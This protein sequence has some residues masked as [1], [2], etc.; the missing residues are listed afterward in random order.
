MIL[1]RIVIRTVG[2]FLI[3]PCQPV[4]QF[5]NMLESHLGLSHDRACVTQNHH[6]GQITD[7]YPT[8]YRNGTLRRRLQA[9]ENLQHGRFTGSILSYQRNAVLLIDDKRN[10]L[11]QRSYS[12]FNF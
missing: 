6:L 11:K 8:L 3:H 7:G 4:L 12:K 10:I 5:K 9:G 2:Q 1:L